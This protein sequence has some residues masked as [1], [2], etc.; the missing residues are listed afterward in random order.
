M[1]NV[2]KDYEKYLT[3]D[4]PDLMI[5]NVSAG[6]NKEAFLKQQSSSNIVFF[7]GFFGSRAWTTFLE[8]KLFTESEEA[9][10]QMQFFDE[11]IQ[12]KINEG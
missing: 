2:F 3:P 12:E 7:E 1:I 6:F 5:N 4:N 11:K 10:F 9:A 8:E